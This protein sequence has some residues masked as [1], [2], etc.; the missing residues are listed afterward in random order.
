MAALHGQRPSR[1]APALKTQ[2][3]SLHSTTPELV[4][5]QATLAQVVP[6]PTTTA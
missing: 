2:A 4:M 3:T 5:E 1:Q 6:T